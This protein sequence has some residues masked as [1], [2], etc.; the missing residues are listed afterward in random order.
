M[1]NLERVPIFAAG[2]HNDKRFDVPDL[3]TMASS[4]DAENLSGRLPVKLGHNAPD[5]APAAGW[6]TRVWRE[7]RTLFATLSDVSEDVVQGIRDGRW[8][9]CSVELLRDVTTATGRTYR[10]LLDGL[11]LLGATRPA[12]DGLAPLHESLSRRARGLTFAEALTFTQPFSE[13]FAMNDETD[14]LRRENE[15]LR[16]ALHRQAVDA[17]VESDVRAR[18]VLPA[19]REQFTRLFRLSSDADYQRVSVGDWCA[20]RASQPRPPSQGPASRADVPDT[21]QAPAPDASLVQKVR[22]Y[23]RDNELR[24]LQ[25]TGERLTFERA[26]TIVTRANPALLAAWRVQ[27]KEKTD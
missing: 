3:D 6:I 25:L 18:L 22:E 8:R 10:Y 5:T 26:A 20:F 21:F 11:A 9:F 27:N 4:F 14:D 7:G 19:A 17:A 24:H 1:A 12:V 13:T 2:T 16:L 15:R 23:L